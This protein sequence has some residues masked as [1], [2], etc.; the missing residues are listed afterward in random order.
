MSTEFQRLTRDEQK[1]A[2]V[3]AARLIVSVAY[4]A[5]A[6][7]ETERYTKMVGLRGLHCKSAKAITR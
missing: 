7:A 6:I 2:K 1:I 4:V 5:A 3:I